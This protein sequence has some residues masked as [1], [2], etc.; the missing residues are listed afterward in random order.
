MAEAMLAADFARIGTL[1][2]ENWR[3]QQ[4]LDPAMSTPEM[5][6]L[7]GAMRDAGV[8]GGK[9][10]GSGAG[11]SMFFLGPDDPGEARN[12]VDRLGMRSLPVLWAPMGVRAC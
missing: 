12:V 6:R 4:V 8:L 3:L 11:G 2:T 9:A 10:A 1:L 5:A 7:E